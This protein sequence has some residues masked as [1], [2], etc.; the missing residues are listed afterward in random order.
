[1]QS[2]KTITLGSGGPS[3]VPRMV[4]MAL[5][6]GAIWPGCAPDKVARGT[7]A[8]QST[9]GTT[10]SGGTDSNS[11]TASSGSG[12]LAG[13]GGKGASGGAMSNGGYTY[14]PASSVGTGGTS[15]VSWT[16]PAVSRDAAVVPVCAPATAPISGRQH[17]VLMVVKSIASPGTIPPLLKAHLQAR[18]FQVDY[19]FIYTSTYKTD[20]GSFTNLWFF[21]DARTKIV[22]VSQYG[23]AVVTKDGYK[24]GAN[25][26]TIPVLC[27]NNQTADTALAMASADGVSSATE[28]AFTLLDTKHPIAAQ[29]TGDKVGTVLLQTGSSANMKVMLATVP[30]TAHV[31]GVDWG[32]ASPGTSSAALFAYEVGDTLA[33]G[34]AAKARR[35]GFFLDDSSTWALVT[36]GSIGWEFFDASVDWLLGLEPC[37]GESTGGT[38]RDAS[39]SDD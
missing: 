15:T 20:A 10:G 33:N 27:G 16:T 2:H 3:L 8:G 34:N 4:S 5:L 36:P 32:A 12:G 11:S 39:V 24:S 29:K 19:A 26:E 25:L 31:V 23:L 22:D 18:G 1:M 17:Q 37:S 38:T 7:L 35:V 9:G 21:D 30:A 28:S 14:V 6:L 13:S